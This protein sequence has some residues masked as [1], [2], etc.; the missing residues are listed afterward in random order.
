MTAGTGVTQYNLWLGLS[1]PGSSSLYAL[2]WV[3]ATSTTLTSLPAKGAT[4]YARLYSL[5]NGMVQYI[6][7]TYTEQ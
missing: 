5:V 1:G 4:V 3:T 2:G 7:Y 6:D